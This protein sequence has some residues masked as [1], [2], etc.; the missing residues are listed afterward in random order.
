VP[1]LTKMWIFVAGQDEHDS[2]PEVSNGL[3][4]NLLNTWVTGTGYPLGPGRNEAFGNGS[5]WALGLGLG[6]GTGEKL[7]C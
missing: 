4:L 3:L 7:S 5:R 2:P 1:G 6:L